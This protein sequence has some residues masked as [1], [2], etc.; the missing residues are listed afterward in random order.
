MSFNQNPYITGNNGGNPGYNNGGYGNGG[1]NNGGF[2]NGGYNNGGY[3]NGGYNNGP[4]CNQVPMN[5][6]GN[7]GRAQGYGYNN[8]QNNGD[9]CL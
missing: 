8:Q 4:N 7:Y 5:R 9:G 3:N 6:F 2:N 1:F